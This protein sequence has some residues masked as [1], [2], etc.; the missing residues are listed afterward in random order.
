[1]SPGQERSRG[2][3]PGSGHSTSGNTATVA[4]DNDTVAR[5]LAALMSPLTPVNWRHTSP[6]CQRPAAELACTCPEH[7]GAR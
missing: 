4:P 6:T 1:M 5:V 7:R 2:A 3:Y